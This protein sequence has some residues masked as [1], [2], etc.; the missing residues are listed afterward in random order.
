MRFMPITILGLIA[1]T[2][3]G[4]HQV[5]S[6]NI[7]TENMEANIRIVDDGSQIADIRASL[8]LRDEL[9]TYVDLSPGEGIFAYADGFRSSLIDTGF[10]YSGSVPTGNPLNEVQVSIE[11]SHYAS[12]FDNFVTLPPAFE[13]YVDYEPSEFGSDRIYIEWAQLSDDPMEIR[14]DGPCLFEYRAYVSR[15][16]DDGLHR[17]S[18]DDLHF[19]NSWEGGTCAAEVIVERVRQ[20]SL[21]PQLSG[22]EIEGVQMRRQTIYLYK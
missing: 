14:I 17:L 10:G 21:D 2:L 7:P 4:C 18:A 6:K 15:F 13:L 20:G 5:A 22:G 1:L 16:G 8:K 19:H 3:T 12:A 11:R 9:F